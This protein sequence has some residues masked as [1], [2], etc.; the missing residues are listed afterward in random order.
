MDEQAGL[1]HLI[2][3]DAFG[4]QRI[5]QMKALGARIPEGK[6]LLHGGAE[7]PVG[8]VAARF[9]ADRL[10]RFVSNRRAASASTS[11]RLARF[12]SSAASAS[13]GRGMAGPP[14]PRAAR[15]PRGSSGPRSP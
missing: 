10:L 13:V 6:A 9:G 5:A 15:P 2:D 14:F 7:A 12:F 11:M 8:E 1:D 4:C 3:A